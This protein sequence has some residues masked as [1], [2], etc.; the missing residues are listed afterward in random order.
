[1]HSGRHEFPHGHENGG[2]SPGLDIAGIGH[3]QP[4]PKGVLQWQRAH[5]DDDGVQEG[6]PA[7]AEPDIDLVEAAFTEGFLGASDPPSFLRLSQV[8]FEATAADGARLVL[9]RV[10]IDAVADVGGITP[11]VGGL[12]FRYDPLPS[13]MVSR[14]KRLRFIYFDGQGPR[15]LKLAEVRQ[16]SSSTSP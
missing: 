9:L 4:A 3:N 10:E 16:L 6:S 8:P 12:S 2:G 15:P 14:R 7:R 1:M 11:H 13:R 5:G